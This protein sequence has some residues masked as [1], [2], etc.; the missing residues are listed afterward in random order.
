MYCFVFI[1]CLTPPIKSSVLI[2][3]NN[4]YQYFSSNIILNVVENKQND[5]Q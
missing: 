1:H 2:K 5:V 4:N 3:L